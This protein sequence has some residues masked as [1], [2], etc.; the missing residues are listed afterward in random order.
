MF[1]LTSLHKNTCIG[2]CVSLL[3]ITCALAKSDKPNLLI[4]QTD[5]HHYGTLGCYGG[6]I[7]ETPHIDSLA[8]NGALATS[9]YATT[10][11]CSPSRA[12]FLSG[13]F[14]QNTGV[15]QND[16]PMNDD[17]VTFAEILSRSGYTT[18]Y[19]GKWHLDGE[20]KPQWAPNRKFGFQDNRFMYN[21]GHWKKITDLPSGPAV[22]AR[23]KKG[24]PSY[25]VDGADKRSYTTDWLTDKTIDFI[26]KN[27][28]RPFCYMVSWP[29]PHGP[30]TV[31][32]PYNTMY[33]H[34]RVPIPKTLIKSAEQIPSWALPDEKLNEQKLTNLMPPYYGMVKC[35]DDNVGR[36]LA[37]LK[38][39]GLMD[40][41][42]IVFTAD[43]GDLC[44]EHGR[45]NKGVP[46]EGSAKIPFIL[47]YPGV[48]EGGVKVHETLSCVDFL[49]TVMSLMQVP[50][51]GKEQGRNASALFTR[52][53]KANWHDVAY[54]RGT[55]G[56]KWLCAV[57]NDLKLVY[58]PKDEP[59]LFDL[60]KDPDEVINRFNDPS[61]RESIVQLTRGLQEYARKFKDPYIDIPVIKKQVNQVLNQQSVRTDSAQ[62]SRNQ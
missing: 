56:T 13:R 17:I 5:E 18:G 26:R 51:S 43:H 4:L 58:S 60:R 61:Y 19:A 11:V 59:W 12:S 44:G 37:E 27:K 23:N 48:I 38:S 41:T 8:R 36:L 24:L 6:R 46:Y 52:N 42:I 20:G 22:A 28:D 1:R 31:R 9:F 62:H 21:R 3:L 10:P 34:V 25:D 54:L 14:P 7:V 50:T 2:L 30:N 39:S 35:I 55:L 45:L 16:L 15:P 49:P 47:Q 32:S 33:N 29:D 57:T 40:N 53:D